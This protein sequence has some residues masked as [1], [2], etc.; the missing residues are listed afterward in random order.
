MACSREEL[1]ANE[2]RCA[3][4]LS[5]QSLSPRHVIHIILHGATNVLFRR[6]AFPLLSGEYAE[7]FSRIM[8]L[9]CS[10]FFI[11]LEINS[12]AFSVRSRRTE[13]LLIE[14]S[15]IF[16]IFRIISCSADEEAALVS[17]KRTKE[18]ALASSYMAAQYFYPPREATLNGPIRSA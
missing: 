5:P 17:V 10:H 14:Q 3:Y 8:P 18:R 2:T 9:C 7:E 15:Q 1:V 6:S 12:L 16:S 11:L 13:R 4:S